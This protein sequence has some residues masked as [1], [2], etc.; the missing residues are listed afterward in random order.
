MRAAGVLLGATI[1]VLA[2][3]CH[4][5]AGADQHGGD[6][7]NVSAP[8]TIAPGA[9]RSGMVWIPTGTL[10]AG[11]PLDEVPRLADVEL[12]GTEMPHGRLLHRRPSLARRGRRHP[13][14]E[15]LARRGRAPLR[16]QGQAPVLRARVG[17]RLQGPRQ[18]ALRVRRHLRLA[19][20]QHRHPR[21]DQRPSPQRR[22]GRVP[23][24]VR[25]ARHARRRLGV[26]RLGMGTRLHQGRG[27]HPRRQRRVGRDRV[28]LRLRALD[29]PRQPL[30][31]PPASAAAPDRATTPRCSST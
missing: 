16:D 30:P 15:R 29:E 25:G 4:R 22:Q 12:P 3:A 5:A 14:D 31:R 17:A 19:R 24:R 8:S 18:H 21:G 13:D 2:A 26:D 11:S 27:R 7:G 6:G 1:G 10:R 20:V 9:P 23:Q 28:A